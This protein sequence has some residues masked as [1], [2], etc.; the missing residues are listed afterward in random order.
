MRSPLA[1]VRRRRRRRQREDAEDGPAARQ[2]PPTPPHTLCGSFRAGGHTLS[3][4]RRGDADACP[5]MCGSLA[6]ERCPFRSW[7]VP[8]SR[9]LRRVGWPTQDILRSCGEGHGPRDPVAI[10]ATES[11][12]TCWS[13]KVAVAGE[14]RSNP[15]GC[16]TRG[17]GGTARWLARRCTPGEA[18]RRRLKLVAAPS[19]SQSEPDSGK[20]LRHDP[21]GP[22][23]PA[24]FSAPLLLV[25][26]VPDPLDRSV[27]A[28][29]QGSARLDHRS[30]QLPLRVLHAGRG[31]AVAA[32]ARSSSPT[33]RSRG[34]PASASSG[35]GSSRCGSP[36]A[37]RWCGRT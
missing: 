18:L 11:G 25:R 32:R 28:P 6:I 20:P 14:H 37:S 23:G 29:R 22:A 34:W 15:G 21:S 8:L 1:G 2:G 27:R 4:R 16:T 5:C 13:R 9:S 10:S 7:S 26:E 33:K 3:R 17:E 36:A 19:R 12:T 35:S 24:E 30:L 31:H